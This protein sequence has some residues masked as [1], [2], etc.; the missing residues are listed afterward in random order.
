MNGLICHVLG[1]YNSSPDTIEM[2]GFISE[3]GLLFE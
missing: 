2:I 1:E 3:K